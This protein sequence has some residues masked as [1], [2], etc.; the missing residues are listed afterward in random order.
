MEDLF[1]RIIKEGEENQK[2][3]IK[4]FIENICPMLLETKKG[5]YIAPIIKFSP[6]IIKEIE[7]HFELD[8]IGE[9]TDGEQTFMF[10]RSKKN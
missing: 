3:T 8:F 4:H 7:K 1:K 5:I 9:K 6:E 2:R 10:V